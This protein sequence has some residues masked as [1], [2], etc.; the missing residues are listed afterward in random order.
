MRPKSAGAPETASFGNWERSVTTITLRRYWYSL[1]IPETRWINRPPF[2]P[3]PQRNRPRKTCASNLRSPWRSILRDSAR[4]LS[5]SGKGP[6]DVRLMFELFQEATFR[7]LGADPTIVNASDEGSFP[8]FPLFFILGEKVPSFS[9]IRNMDDRSV[10]QGAPTFA[11]APPT[12]LGNSF[13]PVE[14]MSRCRHGCP[15][16]QRQ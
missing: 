2:H 15:A 5:T 1:S 14:A 11:S 13:A 16:V 8:V 7:S 6:S 9:S 4:H 12:S 10:A 3:T